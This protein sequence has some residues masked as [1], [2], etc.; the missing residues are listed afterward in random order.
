MLNQSMIGAVA[1]RMVPL[2]TAL[3]MTFGAAASAEEGKYPNW[4]GKWD[5]VG[6]P[7]WVQAGDAAPL[8]AEYQAIHIYLLR[9]LDSLG[10]D[11][12]L[13]F[14]ARLWRNHLSEAPA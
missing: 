7:R 4:K 8:N 10:P 1:L 14:Y 3:M 11:R 6:P 5:R 2:V 13:A 9:T 12:R